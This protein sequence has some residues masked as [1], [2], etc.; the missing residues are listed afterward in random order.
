MSITLTKEVNID[1]SLAD[2]EQPETFDKGFSLSIPWRNTD[3]GESFTK[4]DFE[5]AL[6][7]VSRRIKK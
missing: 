3:E 2:S 6:R 5:N 7:K 4:E 1:N